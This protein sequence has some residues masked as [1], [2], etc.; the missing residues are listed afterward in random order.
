MSVSLCVEL[1]DVTLKDKIIQCQCHSV[2]DWMT[3]LIKTRVLSVSVTLFGTSWHYSE[4]Q[5][6][7]SSVNV[8]LRWAEWR[9]SVLRDKTRVLNVSVT[10]CGTGRNYSERRDYSVSVP[11]C[12]EL[13]DIIQENK[14]RQ[15]DW[16]SVWLVLNWV[17]LFRRTRQDK[18][19]Q[20]QC[21]YVWKWVTWFRKTRQDKTV[22]CQCLCVELRDVIQE[23]QT[24]L[25]SVS[26]T[27]CG[28]E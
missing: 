28:T 19:I 8:T 15:D 3:L 18:T 27:M 12:V 10:L 17:T 20:C 16:V 11:L 26:V 1:N 9:Y 23:D 13:S 2:W 14:T 6:G 5:I 22:Q 7:V 4:R 25:F 24:R 21:D